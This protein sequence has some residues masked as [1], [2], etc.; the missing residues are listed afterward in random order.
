MKGN[1]LSALECFL[2][3]GK[4]AQDAANAIIDKAIGAHSGG[5]IAN[6]ILTMPGAKDEDRPIDYS[7]RLDSLLFRDVVE[8][9]SALNLGDLAHELDCLCAEFPLLIESRRNPPLGQ[10]RNGYRMAVAFEA[11]RRY[12]IFQIY[13]L[14]GEEVDCLPAKPPT[15]PQ[16]PQIVN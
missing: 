15:A 4:S 9:V 5:A 14:L 1:L 6:Q 2:K 8:Q 10:T 12:N 13:S 16:G 7:P 3:R 11:G